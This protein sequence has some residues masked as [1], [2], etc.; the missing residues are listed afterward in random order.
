MV[1]PARGRGTVQ[2]KEREALPYKKST[3]ALGGTREKYHDEK[4]ITPASEENLVLDASDSGGVD[5][6]VACRR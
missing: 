6:G 4:G 5:R 3:L 1:P 2:D